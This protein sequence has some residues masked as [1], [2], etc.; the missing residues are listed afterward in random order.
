M[1]ELTG[2][3]GF[4]PIVIEKGEGAYIMDGKGRK[5]ISGFSGLWNVAVGY[6]RDELVKAA[7][8]QMRELAFGSCFRQTHP[9]A[10]EL[11]DKLVRISPE[12]YEYVYLGTN[13][14]EAVE[15][16][17]KI[18]R[19]YSRQSPDP[20]NKSR[21]KIISLQNSYF[22][23]S[24]AAMSTSGLEVEK[25]QFGPLPDGFEQIDPPYCYRCPYGDSN[26]PECGLKCSAALKNKIEDEGSE[27]VAAFIL[28]PI[29]G[30]DGLSA[31]P[32]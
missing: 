23:V 4:G 6:G 12:Q 32:D 2:F 18:A 17:I 29:M 3:L 10:I 26:Y 22:G 13:G 9:K 28:E 27:T 30:A 24:M 25:E 14:S 1:D 31:P 19:Q 7:S 11:A 21:Y 20:A 8:E 5:Y 15:T 16:A